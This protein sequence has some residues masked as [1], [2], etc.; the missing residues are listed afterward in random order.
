MTMFQTK[1]QTTSH[2]EH[3]WHF[4]KMTFSKHQVQTTS[5]T[6][7]AIIFA[8]LFAFPLCYYLSRDYK[9]LITRSGFM[10]SRIGLL[11][12]TQTQIDKG[13]RQGRC[14]AV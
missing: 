1:I 13:L 4:F 9:C 3:C 12:N 5:E 6:E 8:R 14:T 7:R 2:T 10:T 11:W